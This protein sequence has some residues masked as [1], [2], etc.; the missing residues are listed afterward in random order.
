MRAKL[1]GRLFGLQP[2]RISRGRRGAYL[3]HDGQAPIAIGSCPSGKEAGAT[4]RRLVNEDV[5][6]ANWSQHGGL[7]STTCSS[8]A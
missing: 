4:Y 8:R 2:D 7:T 3:I 1:H 6:K 5:R